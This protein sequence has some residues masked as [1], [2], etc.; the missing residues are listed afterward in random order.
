MT[1]TFLFRAALA[2]HQE[3][4][5]AAR[6]AYERDI[7]LLV[8]QYEQ[9]CAA[10]EAAYASG[11]RE[12]GDA[13]SGV[14]YEAMRNDVPGWPDLFLQASRARDARI[15]ELAEGQKQAL[16]RAVIKLEAAC[17]VPVAVR[18]AAFAHAA[19]EQEAAY[20]VARAEAK[21][22]AWIA[23]FRRV[24]ASPVPLIIRA[25]SCAIW[26]ERMRET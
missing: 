15:A 9:E 18:D 7:Y 5:K 25:C 10:A 17:A 16:I 1:S 24:Q 12:A 2:A 22:E 23:S 21:K 20:M 11:C 4:V 13:A 14:Y 8:G 19:T 3:K 6:A 26:R